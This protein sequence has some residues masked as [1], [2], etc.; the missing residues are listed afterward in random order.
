MCSYS[1]KLLQQQT[2]EA[3]LFKAAADRIELQLMAQNRLLSQLCL[4]HPNL[5]GLAKLSAGAARL[6]L[7]NQIFI[8]VVVFVR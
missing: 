5:T 3:K 2:E 6:H 7:T 4:R 1:T 8:V